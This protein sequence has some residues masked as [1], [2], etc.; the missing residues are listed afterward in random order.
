[1]PG[2]GDNAEAPASSGGL[3]ILDGLLGDSGS[4]GS[5]MEHVR[6]LYRQLNTS[7]TTLQSNVADL[8]KKQE[9]EFLKAFKA[10]SYTVQLELQALRKR[11]EETA[12]RTA[13]DDALRTLQ[14]ERDWFEAEAKSL[15]LENTN[16]QRQLQAARARGQA[17]EEERAWLQAET[18][19]QGAGRGVLQ[20]AVAA[21]TTLTALASTT[22][23]ASWQQRP[24]AK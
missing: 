5:G 11:A 22:T 17:A 13:R 3:T 1:M 18:L 24:W 8:L 19:K 15:A 10:H 23:Y 2:G 14:L 16:L 21:T 4:P 7:T 9:T 20:G 12:S 6:S